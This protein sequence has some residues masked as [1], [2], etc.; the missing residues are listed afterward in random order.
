MKKTIFHAV[1]LCGILSCINTSLFAQTV[2]D[3]LVMKE[4]RV[5]ATRIR[6]PLQKQPIQVTVL[7]SVQLGQYRALNL[8]NLLTNQ[9]FSFVQSYGPG[10]LSSVSQRGYDASHVQVVWEGFVINHPMVGTTDLSLIPV[11]MLS[12]VE[13]SPGNAGTSFGSGSSGGTIYLKSDN[14]MDQVSLSSTVGSFGL[15]EQNMSAGTSSGDFK[16]AVSAGHKTSVNDYSFYNSITKEN[17]RRNNNNLSAG[18]LLAN[19]ALE[20]L[21]FSV[22]SGLWYVGEKN[23]IPYELDYGNGYATQTDKSLRWFGMIGAKRMGTRYQFKTYYSNYNLKYE[24][25]NYGTDSRSRSRDYGA[26]A[27][28]HQFFSRFFKMQGLAK[29]EQTVIRTNNYDGLKQRTLFSSFVNAEYQPFDHFKIYPTLRLDSYSDFGTELSPSIGANYEI[30]PKSLYIRAQLKKDFTAPTFNQL[31][32]STGGNPD[33]KAEKSYSYEAGVTWKMSLGGN[34]FVELSPTFYNSLERDGIRWLPGPN[35]VWSPINIS[36][37]RTYGTEV[38]LKLNY[39]AGPFNLL[40]SNYTT[41]T[42]AYS[43]K[44]EQQGVDIAHKQTPYVPEWITKNNLQ[45]GW[46]FF[47]IHA[48][49][50][51]VGSRYTTADHSSSVDPLSGYSVWD[52]G[53][54]VHHSIS[55]LDVRLNWEV[56]NLFDE[57]YQIVA[58][59]PMPGRYTRLTLSISTKM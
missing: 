26:E 52:A 42:K 14:L 7:D 8:G 46:K 21:N 37:L 10:G 16:V 22:K 36:R 40:L 11:S 31:Y 55:V 20:K 43:L 33:L 57:T 4:I 34:G 38:G 49:Q 30:V 41:W 47:S 56:I 45:I 25:P 29:I 6:E 32:W 23:N 12:S 24:D 39:Q 27:N 18:N 9:S 3:S 1:L 51:W 28:I 44:N 53:V 48:N 19:V 50:H 5:E 35:Y 54:G 58:W 17:E 15:K 13:I 2:S 59:Y